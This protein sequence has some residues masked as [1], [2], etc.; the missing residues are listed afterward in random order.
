MITVE[1]DVNFVAKTQLNVKGAAALNTVTFKALTKEL[2]PNMQE[3]RSLCVVRAIRYY[4]KA[5][6]G[7]RGERKKTVHWI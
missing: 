6:E 1:P 7:V 3:D 5:T 2:A 4:V